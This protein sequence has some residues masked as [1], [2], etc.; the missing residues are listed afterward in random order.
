MRRR[1]ALHVSLLFMRT[2][3]RPPFPPPFFV[4]TVPHCAL[5]GGAA[6]AVLLTVPL[7]SGD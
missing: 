2:A 7:V 4:A 6:V 3:T 5:G 1:L